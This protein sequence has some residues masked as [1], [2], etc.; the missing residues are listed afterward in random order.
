ML[1]PQCLYIL[2]GKM[3]KQRVVRVGDTALAALEGYTEVRGD[4]PG[5]LF[6]SRHGEA[7]RPN[8]LRV[9]LR[10]LAER[11]GI[12]HVYPHR[13]RYTFATWAIEA[14]AR[15]IYIQFLLGHSTPAMVRQHS[16]IYNAEKAARAHAKWSPGDRFGHQDASC[17]RCMHL[18]S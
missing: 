11:A 9:M 16:S 6:L 15:E 14:E 4:Q 17:P 7:S 3:K 5:Q 2:N 13:F 12:P 1:R 8:S 18:R 10:R